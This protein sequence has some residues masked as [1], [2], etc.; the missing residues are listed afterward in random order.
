MVVEHLQARNSFLLSFKHLVNMNNTRQNLCL[1]ALLSQRRTMTAGNQAQMAPFSRACT[2]TSSTNAVPAAIFLAKT[3]HPVT[4]L[5]PDLRRSSPSSP[6]ARH[7]CNPGSVGRPTRPGPCC[8][9]LRRARCC[10]QSGQATAFLVW[11]LG[12]WLRWICLL[13]LHV[14]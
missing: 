1:G 4:H 14:M 10:H 9:A 2:K 11:C 5:E 6:A 13:Y 8:H 12:I 3:H 7:R